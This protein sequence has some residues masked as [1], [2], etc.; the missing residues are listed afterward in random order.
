MCSRP[1]HLIRVSRPALGSSFEIY[2][3][4]DDAGHLKQTGYAALELVQELERQLSHFEPDSVLC[5]INRQAYTQPVV[6]PPLILELLLCLRHW[7]ALTDGAFDPTAGRLVRLWGFFRQGRVQGNPVPAPDPDAIATITRQ[8]GWQHVVL[9]EVES[10]IRFLTPCIELHLGAVGKGWIVQRAADFLRDH[11]ITCA[12]VHSG[13]SSIVALGHPPDMEGWPVGIT[14]PLQEERLLAKVLLADA[15]LS[16]SG[17]TEHFVTIGEKRISHIFDPRTGTP[18]PGFAQIS[19]LSRDA[20]EGDALSTAF[21][22]QGEE[23]TRQFCQRRPD[24]G[25]VLL[26]DP[27]LDL[28][29]GA[30]HCFGN[31]RGAGTRVIPIE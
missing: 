30:L 28:A 20:A 22:V 6:L 7:S 26:P 16:T 2:L 19:V 29:P 23:W 8:I 14:H 10:T 5:Q 27:A 4:G 31:I 11:E 13:Q 18:V 12:L 1:A 17:T 25:V 9:D 3:G 24:L 21:S 15:A